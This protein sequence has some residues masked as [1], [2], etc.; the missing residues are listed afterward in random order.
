MEPDHLAE[1]IETVAGRLE[2]LRA[3][4]PRLTAARAKRAV[5]ADT[6]ANAETA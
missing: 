3:M 5:R 4:Y 6:T 1:S 2:E